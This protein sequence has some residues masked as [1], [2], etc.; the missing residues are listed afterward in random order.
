VLC[1]PPGSQRPRPR[2]RARAGRAASRMN[3]DRGLAT[4]EIALIMPIL[5]L[6][7][8]GL[9]QFAL[10]Y[11]AEQVVIAAAQEGSA[12]ASTQSGSAAAGQSRAQVVMSGLASLTQSTQVTVGTDTGG[13]TVSITSQLKGLIP[14]VVT[15]P[16]HARAT[17]HIEQAP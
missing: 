1:A 7:V 4:L 13:I 17:S 6:I 15:L 10:W 9:T 8:L 16:L 11:H 12:Q 5:V 14:G 2:A 3:V